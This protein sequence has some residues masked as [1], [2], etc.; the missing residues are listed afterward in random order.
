MT[1]IRLRIGRLD[2]PGA[3]R[4]AATAYARALARGLAAAPTPV[5][6]LRRR[7]IEAALAPAT[8]A[9]G[10]TALALALSGKG[11]K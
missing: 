11:A 5:A 4:A 6:P 2:L 7:S 9:A 10:G 1:Q 3:D 8:P